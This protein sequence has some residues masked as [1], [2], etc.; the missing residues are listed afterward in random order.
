M[1]NVN[2]MHIK[3]RIDPFVH[4]PQFIQAYRMVAVPGTK[5]IGSGSRKGNIAKRYHWYTENK[6]PSSYLIVG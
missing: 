5:I 4:S 3:Y 2:I 1:Q 6:I